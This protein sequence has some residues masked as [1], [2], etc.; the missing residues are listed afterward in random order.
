MR[1]FDLDPAST[2]A[3]ATIQASIQ[4]TIQ[5]TIQAIAQSSHW[6]Q[7]DQPFRQGK[8]EDC[9]KDRTLADGAY[10]GVDMSALAMC[11][12][13]ERQPDGGWNC[14]RCNGSHRSSF[15]ATINLLGGLP[16]H[17]QAAGGTPALCTPALC[18]ARTAGEQFLLTRGALPPR[19]D[20]AD[21]RSR[22]PDAPPSAPLAP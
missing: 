22:F 3:R 10:F 16:G 12:I 11:L 14:K 17:A 18:A 1:E 20:R 15:A 7:G 13:A 9:I 2:R 21:S 6:Q 8:T 5:A 4:A 19:R